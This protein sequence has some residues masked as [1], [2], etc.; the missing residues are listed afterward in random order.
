MRGPQKRS[1]RLAI[2]AR[3]LQNIRKSGA[4]RVLDHLLLALAL[5]PVVLVLMCA[6]SSSCSMCARALHPRRQPLAGVHGPPHILLP[7]PQAQLSTVTASRTQDEVAAEGGGGRAVPGGRTS[8]SRTRARVAVV[9][10][11]RPLCPD[12]RFLF[13]FSNNSSISTWMVAISECIGVWEENGRGVPARG[14]ARR[15]ST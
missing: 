10:G 15:T 4:S 6:S 13:C 14:V 3:L 5:P 2:V 7:L 8:R 1:L 12:I 11:D 9:D